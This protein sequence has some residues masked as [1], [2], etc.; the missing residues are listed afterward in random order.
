MQFFE[1]VFVMC[2]VQ[3]CVVCCVCMVVWFGNIDELLFFVEFVVL[4]EQ[5]LGDCFCEFEF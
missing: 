3:E 2:V 4:G 1:Y 5:V